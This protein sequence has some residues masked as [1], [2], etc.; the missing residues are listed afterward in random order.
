MGLPEASAA[1]ATA[2]PPE[3]A[4]VAA[5]GGMHPA[6]QT[7]VS[8]KH[9]VHGVT[10][11]NHPSLRLQ[12]VVA[13]VAAL[14]S[15]VA[16]ASPA[17]AAAGFGDVPG[18][19][20][21][22][23]PVQW[24]VDQ[25]ITNGTGPGCFSPSRALT[26][27][28]LAV[29]LWRYHDEPAAGD[30]PFT[31]VAPT[32]Y[33]R[34]AVAWMVS[35]NVT[36]G[37]SPTTFDPGR[38]VTRGEVAAFVWRAEG[39]PSAGSTATFADVAPGRFYSDAVAWMASSGI[40]TGTSPTTFHPDRAVTRAEIGTFLWRLAG[41][42]AT[43]VLAGGTCGPGGGDGG[44]ET[45][46]VGAAL[47]DGATCAASVTPAPEIRPGNA[48]QNATRGAHPHPDHPRVD[49]D[50][51]GTTDEILQWAACKWG[52]DEDIVRAQA[53]KESWWHMSAQGDF[54]TDQSRCHWS[55]SA[56]SPCGESLGILQVRQPYHAAAMDDA[57]ASTAYNADYTY[58]LWRDCYEGELTWLNQVERG[59]TYGPGDAW[60]CLGVWFSGRWYTAD[61]QQYIEAVQAILADR[62]W[63]SPMFV[64][65]PG[66]L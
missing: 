28:E 6:P 45:L 1:P 8:R 57:V 3:S 4:T 49:G 2:A 52:L 25:G 27:G 48:A 60:G 15:L 22:T 64:A 19:A 18:D 58:A 14:Y 46:P 62:T 5:A 31:D 24:M 44:F 37:T 50:F 36:T 40:T 12:A 21:Y 38:T 55:V 32:D 59:A 26:R 56:L 7:S 51:T 34:D 33:F 30:E 53:V 39:R 65:D 11:S 47:P 63:E 23:E 42:P 54:T 16:A 13:A 43:T 10:M 66:P 29:F 41:R 61:A 35:T 9:C 17:G 20:F